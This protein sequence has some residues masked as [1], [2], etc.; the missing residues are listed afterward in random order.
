M[1]CFRC[2]MIER[3]SEDASKVLTD[4][5]V[6]YCNLNSLVHS[7]LEAEGSQDKSS[8]TEYVE[9]AEATPD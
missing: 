9:S 3:M 5:T 4:C 2:R 6:A 1:D 7:K 8:F